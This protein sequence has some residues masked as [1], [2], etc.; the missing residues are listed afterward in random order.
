MS[1]FLLLFFKKSQKQGNLLDRAHGFKTQL[2]EKTSVEKQENWELIFRFV[3]NIM[4]F[5]SVKIPLLIKIHNR[6]KI[7]EPKF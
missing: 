7:T 1:V 3:A 4:R 6:P 2:S 5:S